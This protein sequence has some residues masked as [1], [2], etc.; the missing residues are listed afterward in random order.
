MRLSI[1]QRLT[2]LYGFALAGILAAAALFLY[3][4]LRHGLDL[5]T[6]NLLE[7]RTQAILTILQRDN[8]VTLLQRRVETDWSQR[9]EKVYVRVETADGRLVTESPR[10]PAALRNAAF[11]SRTLGDG[12][13]SYARTYPP[14]TPP[15][16]T[17]S[18]RISGPESY[19]GWAIYVAA[20]LEGEEALLLGYRWRIA[21]AILGSF[22]VS[23]LLG[24]WI[25]H[26]SLEPVAELARAMSG[27]RSSNLSRRVSV[28]L[29]S[30]LRIL[31]STFNELL[32]RIESSVAKLS[33]FSAD[34]AHELRNPIHNIRG[35][36]EVALGRCREPRDY[37]EV[38][39]S[40]LE[41]CDRMK[42]IVD[43]LLFLAR[44]ETSHEAPPTEQLLLREELTNIIEFYDAAAGEAKVELV[45][46][47]PE[48][49][50]LRAHRPL[51]QSAIGN[52][53]SNAIRYTPPGSRV[54]LS[55]RESGGAAVIEVRDQGPGIPAT[56]LPHVFDRL[57]R[58]DRQR[59]FDGRGHVG[60]GLAI[61]QAILRLHQGRAEIESD[62]GKGTVVRLTFPA[63]ERH[64]AVIEP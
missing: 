63:P 55:A 53:L 6:R 39:S 16:L 44:M 40:C 60:L 56:D 11:D 28:E 52:L 5:E 43:S 36:M 20:D 27:I 9:F 22:L 46:Q 26:R 31:G 3:L 10:V 34:I 62:L 17:L 58:V 21:A 59:S 61:V 18:R 29:P 25:V 57:Y 13:G 37:Q 41:E 7:D 1:A 54:I 64:L 2:F 50:T 23:L 30:E 24:R 42:S 49:L 48:G 14:G 45:L 19:A 47:V 15:F 51:L 12:K 35:E 4:S 38:L 8:S 32:D 33:Q